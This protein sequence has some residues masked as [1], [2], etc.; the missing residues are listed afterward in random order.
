MCDIEYKSVI[1]SNPPIEIAALILAVSQSMRTLPFRSGERPRRNRDRQRSST[2]ADPVRIIIQSGWTT[3]RV[4]SL[5]SENWRFSVN[6]M[7]LLPNLQ[8]PKGFTAKINVWINERHSVDMS[9]RRKN[10]LFGSAVSLLC[11]RQDGR[12]Q[13]SEYA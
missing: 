9:I 7:P 11:N 8:F 12:R 3:S 4:S 6:P 2:T 5:E 1:V 10:A 13:R